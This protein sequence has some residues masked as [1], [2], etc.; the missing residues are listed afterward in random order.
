M[1]GRRGSQNDGGGMGRGNLGVDLGLEPDEGGRG[2]SQDVEWEVVSVERVGGRKVK[3][4]YELL[5]REAK[6]DW[7]ESEVEG[8]AGSREMGSR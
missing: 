6:G 5:G 1:A 7:W 8:S 4:G 3:T 2:L